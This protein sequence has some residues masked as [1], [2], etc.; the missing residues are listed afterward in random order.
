MN[1]RSQ[2]HLKTE[3]TDL[4]HASRCASRQQRRARR[5]EWKDKSAG[6]ELEQ[7]G[8]CPRLDVSGGAG[9][10]FRGGCG[11]TKVMKFINKVTGVKFKIT[12]SWGSGTS[13][14]WD[15]VTMLCWG[16]F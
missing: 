5:V 7:G 14:Q 1:K 8:G 15:W 11:N 6:P 2:L 16:R 13:E 3:R 10:P 4:H 9:F 12:D